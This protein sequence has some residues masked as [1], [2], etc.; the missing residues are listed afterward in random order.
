M[1]RVRCLLSKAKLPNSLWGETLLTVAHVINLS[2]TLLSK[3]MYQIVFGTEMMF[4]M[5]I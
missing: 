4:S 3:V 1:E 2:P 5:T